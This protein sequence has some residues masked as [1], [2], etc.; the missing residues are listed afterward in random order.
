MHVMARLT[1]AEYAS[2]SVQLANASAH[3]DAPTHTSAAEVLRAAAL[4]QEEWE[5]ESAHWEDQLSEA[6]DS[7]EELPELVIAY[8]RAVQEAQQRLS[9][10]T[11]SLTA[12]ASLLEELQRGV[13]FDQLL[14]R[15]QLSL[16]EF[17]TAQHHWMSQAAFSAEVRQVLECASTGVRCG[18]G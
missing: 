3:P 16:A 5:A 18:H 15:H 8:S 6:M 12:F 1:I 9:S 4:T 13:P 14:K 17:L 11:I 10:R 2:L 7:D